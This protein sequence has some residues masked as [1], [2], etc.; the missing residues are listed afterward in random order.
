MLFIFLSVWIA[1]FQRIVASL[2]SVIGSVWCLY[3]FI[4]IIIVII[5][6]L[7]FIILGKSKFAMHMRKDAFTDRLKK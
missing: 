4:I 7:N 2:G 3:H 5:I 1:K 6:K